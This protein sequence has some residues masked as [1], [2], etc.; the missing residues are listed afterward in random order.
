MRGKQNQ[1]I[2]NKGKVIIYT[3]PFFPMIGGGELYTQSFAKSLSMIGYDVTVITPTESDNVDN[4]NFTVHR[5]SHP[6]FIRGFN[7]NFLEIYSILKKNKGA[8]FNISGPTSLDS[9]M[10]FLCHFLKIPS[11]L[12]FHGK[13]NSRMGRLIIKF[14]GTFFYKYA[15]A[16]L[17]QTKREE[18]YLRTLNMNN[19]TSVVYF[20]G[21]DKSEFYCNSGE[22]AS[23]ELTRKTPLRF[24]FVG[25]LSSSRPYKG[26]KELISIFRKTSR[27]VGDNNISLAIVG[28]GDLL[29][30]IKDYA[31][32]CRNIHFTG[33]VSN[34]NL[35]EELCKSDA[36]ILPSISE[37]EGF[38][39]VVL[40]AISCGKLVIVSKYAGISELIIKYNSGLIFDPLNEE[41]SII[42]LRYAFENREKMKVLITNGNKMMDEEGLDIESSV[43]N[44]A[45]I[46]D[47]ILARK[48]L[49][50]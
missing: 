27:V 38:G 28:G 40:E 49:T 45:K 14:A 20:N 47:D 25:G 3:E 10:L 2:D 18:N 24:I 29:K 6:V 8:V 41:D 1:G 39:R 16:I 12:T 34:D 42:K 46:Y 35:L 32:D 4:F 17:V 7:V 48:E 50:N 23:A 11:I 36:L 31:R 22:K 21:V 26:V 9:V 37:G 33:R 44:T 15:E 43:K 19:R 13:L 5:L 30:E